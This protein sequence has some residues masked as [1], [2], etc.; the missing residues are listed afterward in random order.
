[1]GYFAGQLFK[2]GSSAKYFEVQT[3]DCD[4]FIYFIFERLV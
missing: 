1:M 4:N 3:V 2:E